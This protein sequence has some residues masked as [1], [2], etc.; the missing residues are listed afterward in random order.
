MKRLCTQPLILLVDGMQ[1]TYS[2]TEKKGSSKDMIEIHSSKNKS[3]DSISHYNTI[4][5]YML[6]F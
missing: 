1:W 5:I 2:L 6:N 3:D 4:K